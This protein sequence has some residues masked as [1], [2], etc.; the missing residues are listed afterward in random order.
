MDYPIADNYIFDFRLAAPG[1]STANPA[2]ELASLG[3]EQFLSY[4]LIRQGPPYGQLFDIGDTGVLDS[5][6]YPT[7]PGFSWD[8]PGAVVDN[9]S[10]QNIPIDDGSLDY[11]RS[12]TGSFSGGNY[13]FSFNFT[14]DNIYTITNTTGSFGVRIKYASD[15]NFWGQTIF[16]TYVK[17]L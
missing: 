13:P 5:H 11:Y 9:I 8:Y 7:G 10:W 3:I 2:V 12:Y 15:N 1:L 6:S 4:E 14:D 16:T 17:E